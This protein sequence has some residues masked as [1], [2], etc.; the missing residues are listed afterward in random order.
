MGRWWL[1]AGLGALCAA[2]PAWDLWK[3]VTIM[4]ITS[5]IT[6]YIGLRSNNRE[7][8]QPHSS[9]EN[10]IKDLLSMAQYASKCGKLRSGHRTG[11]GQF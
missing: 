2:V 11:K 1:A 5:F 3:E 4:F 7:G 10:W 8:T 9:K 6:S